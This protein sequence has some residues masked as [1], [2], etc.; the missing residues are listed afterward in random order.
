VEV[1]AFE[2]SLRAF[3]RRTPFEAF[4]VE[5]SS[6]SRF[7]VRHPEALAFDAGVAVYINPGGV[8]ILFDHTSVTQLIRSAGSQSTEAA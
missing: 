4:T 1:D 7:A 6:G 3:V 5:L 8:P 2:K